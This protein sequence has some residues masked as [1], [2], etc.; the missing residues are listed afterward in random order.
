[1]SLPFLNRR[2]NSGLGNI[3]SGP[4]DPRRNID[5]VMLGSILT[6]GII[7]VFAIYSAT[8]WKVDSDPYWFS[9]RQV[10]FLLA[11]ALAVVVVM[12]FDYQMLR[13]RAY[14]LYGVSLIAL[15]LVLSVG[16]LK[17]GARLS[18]DFGPIA[19]QPAEFAKPAVLVA[20]AAFYS[21]TR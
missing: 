21:D 2:P 18:F 17:G 15:V 5:W 9:V 19:F 3:R 7:G 4:S 16:A 20:L 13:E 10:A 11:S 12:S 8:F 14:F 6:M 1:M